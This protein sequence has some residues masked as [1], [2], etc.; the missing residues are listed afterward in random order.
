LKRKIINGLF[1]LALVLSFSLVTVTPSLAAPSSDATL[2]NLIISSGTLT[3]AFASGTISYTDSVAHNMAS[4]TVTPTVH[5]SHATVT[6]NGTTVASGSASGAIT[7]SVGANPITV[8]ITAQD[9][10]TKTYTVTVTGAG[11]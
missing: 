6:V 5:E 11:P 1:A 7:L 3:P 10:T 4:I 2:S 9:T 8:V